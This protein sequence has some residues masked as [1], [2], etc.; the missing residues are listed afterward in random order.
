MENLTNSQKSI[1][2][3]EQYYKG[4]SVNTISGSAIIDEKLDFQKLEKSIRIVCQKHDNFKIK[5]KIKDGEIFQ[6][7]TNDKENIEFINLANEKEFEKFR[8]KTIKKTFDLESQLYKF[9]II[10]FENGKG[11]FLLNIH[12]LISDAWTLALICNDIIKTYSKLINN[13]EIETKSIYSYI[14]YI[15]SE[16]EYHK[17]EKYKIDKNYWLEKYKTIP[18]VA[19]IPGSKQNEANISSVIGERKQFKIEQ[20]QVN[21]I[22]E[23]CKENKISLYNF[24]M[25]VYSIYIAEISNLDDFAI[26]TPI[27]NRTNFKEK[28]TAGMFI[29]MA[30]LRIKFSEDITFKDFVKNIAIESLGMLKHQKYSYQSLI[31][32]LRKKDK[33]IPNLYNILLSYQ[34]TNTQMSGE[35]IK[36][37]VDWIFNGCSANDMDIQIFDL[38]DTGNLNIA[39]DYKKNIYK[40]IDIENLH[41]RILHIIKQITNN[42]NIKIQELEITTQE[43][44]E[45]LLKQY[46]NTKVEYNKSIPIIKYF[47]KEVEKHPNDIAIIFENNRMTYKELNEKANSLAYK[48]IEIGVKNNTIIGIMQER[49]IEIIVAILAVLKAGGCYIP[50]APDYPKE[51]IQYMLNDSNAEILLTSETSAINTNKKVLNIKLDNNELYCNNKE[52]LKNIS[53]SHD[54]A[55]IIYTSGSTGVPKGVMITQ[56]NLTN[57]YTAM[58]QNIDYLKDGEKHKIIS[59]TTISFDIFE[60]ETLISLTNGL[61]VFMTNENEQKMTEKIENIIKNNDIDVLQTTPSIM[62]FHL[63][64]LNNK[65]NLKSLKYIMLAGEQLPKRL[66]YKIKNIIDDI[67]IYNG[68]GPSETTIFSSIKKIITPG[69]ITIGKPIANTRIYI[70]NKNSKLLPK[71]IPGEM[72][73]SG[74]GVGKG[75]INKKEQTMSNFQKDI[76]DSQ[77]MMYRTGDIGTFNDD[78]EIICYG[79]LD[80]QV[81]IRGLRIELDEIEKQ[82]LSIYNI[83]DCIIVKKNIENRDALCAYYISKGPVDENVIKNFLKNKLPQYMIP[84][85]FIKLETLP[86]TPNGKIDKKLLPTPNI[87]LVDKEFIEARNKTDVELIKIIQKM[88]HVEKISLSETLLDLGGDSLTAI[89][90]STKILSKFNVQTNVKDILTN[91]T[92]KDISDYIINNQTEEKIFI[93]IPNASGKELYPL[94]TAQKR[95]YYS[96]KM[97][98][99]ENT[100]YNLPGGILIDDILDKEKIKYIFN[101]IIKRHEILRTSF[102]IKEDDIFQ[103]IENNIKIEIPVYNNKKEEIKNLLNNFSKPFNLENAPLIRVEIHYIDN[104]QTLLL[105]ETHHIVMD[106]IGLNNLIIEFNRLYNGEDLK[107]IPIQYKDYAVWENNYINSK[108]IQKN[109]K[110]WLGKFEDIDLAPL[111]LP[112]DYKITNNRSYKGSK[113]SNVINDDEFIKIEKYSKKFGVSPYMFFVSTFLIM[114]YKYTGQDDITIGS[115]IANRSINELKRMI[116]MFGN[117][118]VIRGKINPNITFLEFLHKIKEQILDDLSNQPYPFDMLVKKMNLKNNFSN[119]PLFD[120]M[121]TYQNKEE[122]IIQIGNKHTQIIELNNDI[123]KFNLSIEIKPK[124]HTLNIEYCTDLFKEETIKRLFEHYLNTINCIL[125]NKDI[126]IKDICIISKEEEKQILTQFNNTKTEFPKNK[127]VVQL[128]EEQVKKNPNNVSVVFCDKKIT[129][130]ELNEKSNQLANYLI[131][132]GVH[133][134]DVIPLLLDKSLEAI[135][136]IIAILKLGGIY[137]PIDIGY[138]KERIEYILK[139]SKSNILLTSRNL[140]LETRLLIKKIYIDLDTESIYSVCDKEN[141]NYIGNSSD[142][143][144]IM[145]TSGSTGKP[146]GVMVQ[147]KNIVRLVKNTNYIEFKKEDKILQTGSI[148]FDACTFE[149]WGALLNGLELYIIKK[150]ELLDAE[151]FHTYIIKNKISILWL[152][153]PLFNQLT[154]ENPHMFSTVRCVLTGGDVLSCKHINMVRKA[155]PKLILIN[156]YGPTENTTFS[157]CFKIEKEYKNSIPIGIPIS[158][159]TCYI[160][161]KDENLQPIGIPGELWV[162]GDGVGKGYLN[163]IELTEK[164]FIKNPFENGKTYKTGDLAKWNKDG[165]IEFLGRIDSQIKIR[166]FRVELSEIT[167]VISLY[168]GIKEA[169]T[170]CR[171]FKGEKSI[172]T[173]IVS[174][175]NVDTEKVKTYM[176]KFLPQYMIPKYIVQVKYL[177]KNQNGKIDKNALP[178]ITFKLNNK[179]T[180]LKPTSSMEDKIIEILKN[181]LN[182]D[183][184]SIDDNFFEIG[185]DSIS[186]MRLQIEALRNNINI[187]YGDIFKYPV[188]KQMANF[189]EKNIVIDR[190]NIVKDIYKY[191]KIIEKNVEENLINKDIPYTPMG[192]ILITGVTGFLGI[193]ILDSYLKQEKGIIYCLIRSKNHISSIDRLKKVLH[194]YFKNKYDKYI[195]NRIQCIEGDITKEKLG[196]T[197]EEYYMIGKNITTLI[198][199]AALVKHFGNIKEFEEINVN[200]TKRIVDFCKTFNIRLMHISTISVSGNNFAEGAYIKN[201]IKDDIYYGENNFYVGQNLDNVYVRSKFLAEEEVLKGIS[202]GLSAYI[203]RMGNLTSRYSEGKF[204]QNHL[205]NAFVSRIKTFLQI[206]CI[207]DYMTNGYVEFTPIDY[208]ADS[209]VKIA[210]HY[211]K[212]FSIFHILNYKHLKL[213]KFYD[214]LKKL[215]INVKI[216]SSDEFLKIIDEILND[217]DKTSILQGIIRDFDSDRKLIYDSNI[218]ITENFT[219]SFLKKIDFEWPEID[220][221]YIRKYLE[222]LI[223]IGYLN[224]KLKED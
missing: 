154:E 43:E 177:P 184:I 150:E 79:R 3:T 14:D 129:Y 122:N 66:V 47:E 29:N 137:L 156:G 178:E 40:K 63:E 59:I 160:M 4:S 190:K 222:Y 173:Y 188:V 163:N 12:H 78:G 94:S 124:T 36:Y 105:L 6:E 76:F 96:D 10:K 100:V 84:Q 126:K 98:G 35:N 165:T 88:L 210:N 216:V 5:L 192:N 174:D 68:Y 58:K 171:D 151:K 136:A 60:F 67:I 26:G 164:N 97:I 130:K 155:N 186:A 82:I 179:K 203:L 44:K 114:L 24:F 168:N 85:Y 102:V 62:K 109:E 27:L 2:V 131:E 132:K 16:K 123:S 198:H 25:A 74:D 61:T 204:Q 141:I 148:V 145:Y 220:I 7:F 103:K 213:T 46:N 201:N 152:T 159:S 75:Y 223:G 38:N 20:E 115:P 138:P 218:K 81:K 19:T 139:D 182:L 69:N 110:Y 86:Y 175:E 55:Y 167:T 209:I 18:E 28:N 111:N 116:G 149:I 133:K 214:I 9:Y 13:Q 176:A 99:K 125:E 65:N 181:V 91:Y 221:E 212:E 185:G 135:V 108:N 205:E 57:F 1:W 211:D 70:L 170:I 158:N 166:G 93:K 206:G 52:N 127:T 194:F 23:Y 147:H 42:D 197:E 199:S 183:E 37:N 71:G 33:N 162:G 117:N 106:G 73:I 54:L 92:I 121:F 142:L 50:I 140:N 143:A 180:I 83:K 107:E 39:Y 95:I 51:R 208:S 146:K 191:D 153:A 64:N 77:R 119:N 53:K 104:N 219:K 128:F 22:K 202:E 80:N 34:I 172:C 200:G 101:R 45:I 112:Y 30:P 157:C 48:L 195:G 31:E 189:I 87:K 11:A 21:K 17:S 32:E 8:I 49:S 207:P 120:I 144:Y 72:Y 196:L 161:S 113:I 41:K 56:K 224:I 90:L 169:Y 187:T 89:T 215:G 15:K 217:K 134:G 118:I 193:H